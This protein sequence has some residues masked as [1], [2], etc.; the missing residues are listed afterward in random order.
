MSQQESSHFA[1]AAQA[2]YPGQ[3]YNTP[4]MLQLAAS[5][6][7][8]QGRLLDIGCGDGQLLKLLAERFPDIEMA[9]LT[10]SEEERRV[11]GERFDV[12]VGDM[13]SLPWQEAAFDVVISRHSLEHSI[14]PLSALFEVNRI[15]RLDGVFHVVVPAPV[16][17]WVIK[18]KDHFSVLPRT[19][20]EKLFD[21]AGFAVEQYQEG[22]WLASF[23]MQPEAEMRFAL[24]KVRDA[25]SGRVSSQQVEPMPIATAPAASVPMLSTLVERRIVVVLHNLVLFDAIRPVV[26]RFSQDVKFLVPVTG[27]EG[28][29]AMGE[30]TCDGIIAA[31]FKAERIALPADIR[32]DIELSPYPYSSRN[33]T[34]AKWRVRFMYGLAKEAWNFSLENNAYYDFVLAYGDYDARVLSAYSTPVRVGNPKIKSVRRSAARNERPVLLYLPTYGPTSSIEAVS[35][36]QSQLKSRFRVIAKAHHGTTYLEPERTALLQTWV[37]DL[38]HH[39]TNLSSLL[40][41]ANVVLSDGSGAIF[42]AI[43]AEVPV[44]V[45]QETVLGGL[46]GTASLEERIVRDGLILATNVADDIPA[47]LD[48]AMQAGSLPLEELRRELFSALGDE[49]A[50][51]AGAFLSELLAGAAKYETFAV[52]RRT[53]QAKIA[54]GGVQRQARQAAERQLDEAYRSLTDRLLAD[55]QAS[56]ARVA[57]RD[58]QIASLNQAVTE[59]DGQ[60][61]SLNEAVTEREV[62]I[63]SL[64]QA[65]VERDGKISK[66]NNEVTKIRKSTSWRITA[67]VRQ[68]KR[69]I[70]ASTRED[71]RYALL[72]SIYWRLPERLR[73]LL[74]KPRHNFVARRLRA[75][76]ENLVASDQT[77]SVDAALMMPWVARALVENK[78]AV[79]PCGFEFDEL[80]NQRPINAAKHYSAKGFLVLYVAW[81]W[82]PEESLSK[83]AGEVFSNV[84]QVPLYEF[85]KGYR[86]LSLENKISHYIITMPARQFT[87]TVDTWRS[88]GG[89]VIYD[90]MDEWEEFYRAGQAPWYEKSLEQELVLKADFVS[91]VSP[92]LQQKFQHIRTDITVIGNGYTPSTLGVKNKGIAGKRH[93]DCIVIGYFGHLTDA[94]FDWDLLFSV[95]SQSVDYHFEII[96]Y[97]EP[98]WVQRKIA[99]FDNIS[100]V[101]KVLPANLHAYVSRWTVAIIPFIQ[102]DLSDAVDPIKIYEYLY[103]GLPVV[104]T[105]IGHLK[106]YPKTYFATSSTIQEVIA[107]AL[108]DTTTV[109]ALE[110]FLSKTTWEARFDSLMNLVSTKK[111]LFALYEH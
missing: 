12:R 91:A 44:A 89:I 9:G 84:I 6:N 60:I 56:L 63:N 51:R 4:A 92:R 97:G 26:E 23:S 35:R 61:D 7:A 73:I 88:N 16:S 70:L 49:A 43:A 99:Q 62:R 110:A 11:C 45:F 42:D 29:D 2:Y 78:I 3:A 69:L 85:L 87:N 53:L 94:W 93:D 54:E 36:I 105:G 22:T 71:A 19:M 72:K 1:V 82:T 25:R 76:G 10:V 28:F 40:A 86:V 41:S 64:N 59:R 111:G 50:E 67:P 20:W 5:I 75:C 98:E 90:I 68:V 33:V 34:Q 8:D 57:E 108:A 47:A 32:C 13:H 24:R 17:E 27:D 103:F 74:N 14:S 100:L 66:L 52:A 83:G 79:I 31:G 46:N 21:D 77:R 107:Q 55:V 15:L 58:A 80:V 104:V 37:D 109:D 48:R 38:A 30:R 106:Y 95:A 18:W 81:Q 39:D 101:G 65:V 102:S 96:G